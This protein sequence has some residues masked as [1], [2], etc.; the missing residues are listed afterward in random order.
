VE[1]EARN[2]VKKPQGKE[3]GISL[4]LELH[5]PLRAKKKKKRKKKPSQ[6]TMATM[7]SQ[8]IEVQPT[9]E[10]REAY[11]A[12]ATARAEIAYSSIRQRKLNMLRAN[13]LARKALPDPDS[14]PDAF[15]LGVVKFNKRLAEVETKVVRQFENILNGKT[16]FPFTDFG[17]DS[18]VLVSGTKPKRTH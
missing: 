9:N 15:E 1:L 17:P 14:V 2:Q 18:Q 8:G 6:A 11:V 13:E 7:N 5:A 10:E 4:P 16:V 12:G 3:Y